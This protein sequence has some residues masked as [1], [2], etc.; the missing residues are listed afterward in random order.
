MTWPQWGKRNFI[1]SH[2]RPFKPNTAEHLLCHW[3]KSQRVPIVFHATSRYWKPQSSLI[4][5]FQTL[6]HHQMHLIFSLLWCFCGCLDNPLLPPCR[7]CSSLVSSP[8]NPPKILQ[9]FYTNGVLS[10]E[11]ISLPTRCPVALEAQHTYIKL[12]R[13]FSEARAHL[14]LRRKRNAQHTNSLSPKNPSLCTLS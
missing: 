4:L 11:L 9:S 12:L 14:T 3:M 7:D 10:S 6:I 2:P 1:P 8:A 5:K 13:W